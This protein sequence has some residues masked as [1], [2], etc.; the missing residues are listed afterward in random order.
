MEAGK[1]IREYFNKQKRKKCSVG[2]IEHTDECPYCVAVHG[3]EIKTANKL[4]NKL[5]GRKQ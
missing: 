1:A 4:W 3:Y 5:K 2:H